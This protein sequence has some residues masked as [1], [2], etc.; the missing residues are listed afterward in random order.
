MLKYRSSFLL[1][2]LL[3]WASMSSAQNTHRNIISLNDQWEFAK[4]NQPIQQVSIPHTWNNQDV[5]DD[6]SGYFRGVGVYRRKLMLDKTVQGKQVFLI[7][8]GANQQTQVL[9]NG[10]SA[11]SHIGGYTKFVVPIS[12][13][14]NYKDDVLEVRVDNSFNENIPP[15]TADFTFFGG[16]Y[17][18]VDLLITPAVHFSTS[19]H[20]SNGV[21]ISTPELSSSS[22]RVKII[23]HVENAA[24]VSKKLMVKTSI[25]DQR[26]ILVAEN[27]AK[28]I[29]RLANSAQIVQQTPLI[30]NP[31]LW[32]P[33]NPYLYRAVTQIIDQRGGEVLD[34][35]SNPVG[36]RWFSFDAQ[37]GFFLNGKP[38]KLIGASRHQDY[39]DLGN[40]LPDRLQI[41]DV[42][43]LKSMGSN[44]LRI[45]HYPQDPLILQ[46]CDRLGILASVEIPVV[47]TITESEAFT[48]NCLEMQTEMIQQ[49]YNHPS[50]I[51]WAYMNEILLR[52]KFADDKPRQ[53]IYFD[54]IRELA[55]KLEDLTR[56]LD[57]DRYTLLVN[58]GAFDLYNKVG[59]T[60][61][62]MIVGWNLYSG[63]YSGD[64]G[65]FAKFLDRHHRELPSKPFLVTEYGADADP[66]IR[67]AQPIR[68]DKSV[69]YAVKFHQI[70]LDA[71][72]ERPFVAGGMA[73]NLADFSSETRE[74]SMPHI[75]NKG[76]LTIARKPKDT[77]F[78]YQSYLLERPYLKIISA[79]WIDRAGSADTQQSLVSTQRLTIATNLIAV[80]LSLNG[81]SLGRK[82]AVNHL[83]EWQVPFADGLNLLTVSDGKFSDHAEINFQLIPYRFSATA[84]PFK[85]LNILLGAQRIYIDEKLHELWIPSQAYREGSWG[86]IGGK[87]YKASNNRI[88]YGSDKDI[89]GSENDP[90]YQSQ[91]TGIK[92]F[93]FDVQDGEY[94]LL[95]HFAELIGGEQ[96]EMLAYN[97]DNSAQQEAKQERVF[98]VAINGR[99][100]LHNVNIARD[101][102]HAVAVKKKTRISAQGGR[103]IVIDFNG[104]TAE[105]ILNAIQIRK[106]Y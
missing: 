63:W 40:A 82:Q 47:N 51:I 103:G 99:P 80:E 23:S 54:H 32:S 69:E 19:M 31:H 50:V 38:L 2:S 12:A 34:E 57:P 89:K 97:L 68:F 30:K 14:L 22:A 62:P 73:W 48:R 13:Y 90:V 58:H 79:D 11:A 84:V 3:I 59:L 20:G 85:D 55:Q 33:V 93:R 104:I 8:N 9:I 94:E 77:Y 72:L 78:L 16:I 41:R 37:N 10:K 35:I 27:S 26:G 64:P 92:Q 21:F 5:L 87:A 88:P 28:V 71:M 43:L 83:I 95:L 18:N 65:D 74:E 96:K 29:F 60:K 44:F 24:A 102:G 6:Q 15:L 91:I 75:N 76:L 66:R 49:N 100:F 86:Y 46:A 1:F 53:Q 25:Y 105:P 17:R 106:I 45:A 98:N 70:Y 56:R 52:T 67:S 7:F 101:F 42:E 39:Q 81:K 61:I 4:E 36:F